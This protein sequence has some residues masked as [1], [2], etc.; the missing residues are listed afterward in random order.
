MT[1]QFI[2]EMAWPPEGRERYGHR[3]QYLVL[4]TTPEHAVHR[5]EARWAGKIG[6]EKEHTTTVIG[7]IASDLFELARLPEKKDMV[8]QPEPDV[9]ERCGAGVSDCATFGCGAD[10]KS[11]E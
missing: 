6:G 10:Q 3:K 5:A 8:L 9:C 7:E 1:R 2:V 11:G 4:T